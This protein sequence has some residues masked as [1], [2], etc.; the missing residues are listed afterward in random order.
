[1]TNIR[2]QTGY[3]HRLCTHYEDKREYYEQIFLCKFHNLDKMNFLKNTKI[4][5]LTQYEI[6]NLNGPI[7]I[8]NIE[9]II[10]KLPGK[11]SPCP[12]GFIGEFYKTFEKLTSALHNL[13][14]KTE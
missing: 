7:I 6:D 1:M 3:H 8:K 4:L 11:K 5:P 9:F 12:E 14:Q 2:N 10:L 13:V